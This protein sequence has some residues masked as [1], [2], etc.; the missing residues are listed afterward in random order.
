VGAFLVAAAQDRNHRSGQ[1]SSERAYS[2]F[3]HPVSL[4]DFPRGRPH[5]VHQRKSTGLLDAARGS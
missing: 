4:I 3:R 2:S 1:R 5:P